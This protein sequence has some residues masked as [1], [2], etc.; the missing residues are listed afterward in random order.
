MNHFVVHL[1]V[2]ILHNT[3]SI[4]FFQIEVFW[5]SPRTLLS[6]PISKKHNLFYPFYVATNNRGNTDRHNFNHCWVLRYAN[7]VTFQIMSSFNNWFRLLN[8]P[9][10]S[11]FSIWHIKITHLSFYCEKVVYPGI[12]WGLNDERR[13]H[14]EDDWLTNWCE[15]NIFSRSLTCSARI[16]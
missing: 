15:T 8:S 12:I 13:G 3:N 16:R 6:V 14:N 10:Y 1:I 5:K 4:S 9:L 2:N 7:Y 11:P